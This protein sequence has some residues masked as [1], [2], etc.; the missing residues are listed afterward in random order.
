V[1]AISGDISLPCHPVSELQYVIAERLRSERQDLRDE[2]EG[3]DML[4][5]LADGLLELAM[6]PAAARA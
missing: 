6:G 2:L 5:D 3:R 4:I 1:V